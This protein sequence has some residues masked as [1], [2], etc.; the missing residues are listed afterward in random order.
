MIYHVK[1]NGIGKVYMFKSK[2]NLK[3]GN[4]Y[5]IVADDITRY[6]S[7]VQIIAVEIDRP[8]PNWVR[9]ITAAEDIING[10]TVKASDD[11]IKNVYFNMDNGITTVIWRDDV[12]TMVK[13]QEDDE[14]DPEK[15]IALCYMK[16]ML[17]NTGAFNE[18]F[19]K[20]LSYKNLVWDKRNCRKERAKND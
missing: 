16:R 11:R 20:H 1:Y 17:G 15:A 19:K 2:L 6:G 4:T 9:T 14:F 7:P 18:V 10:A 3:V 12:R 13:C 8:V 5:D